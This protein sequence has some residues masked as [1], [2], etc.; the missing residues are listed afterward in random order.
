MPTCSS[1]ALSCH[2]SKSRAVSGA[3]AF[4]G[5]QEAELQEHLE[6]AAEQDSESDSLEQMLE[7]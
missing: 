1:D 7:A 5:F 2:T 6:E 3:S 4:L